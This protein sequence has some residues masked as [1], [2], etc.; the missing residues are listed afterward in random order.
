MYPIPCL[1]VPK[2]AGWVMA[3]IRLYACQ[4]ELAH[5]IFFLKFYKY[6]KYQVLLKKF[7]SI[8]SIIIFQQNDVGELKHLNTLWTTYDPFSFIVIFIY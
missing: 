3:Q 6:L 2:L 1:E 8:K 7:C 5:S 4:N